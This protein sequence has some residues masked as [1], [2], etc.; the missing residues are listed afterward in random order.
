[1]NLNRL[2]QLEKAVE[3]REL[4]I[5]VRG[6]YKPIIELSPET[7]A[8]WDKQNLGLPYPIMGGLSVGSIPI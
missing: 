5:A 7:K 4:S 6:R 1:M 2:N 3:T 8:E